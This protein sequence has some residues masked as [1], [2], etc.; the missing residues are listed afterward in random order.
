MAEVT[1]LLLEDAPGQVELGAEL[2]VT[3]TSLARFHAG[4]RAEK[5]L[6]RGVGKREAIVLPQL[7]NNVGGFWPALVFRR[8]RVVWM[9]VR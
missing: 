2:S 8:H 6:E 7:D 4:V 5:R 9:G 3:S 1:Y